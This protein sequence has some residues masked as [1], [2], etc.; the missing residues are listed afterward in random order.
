MPRVSK[1]LQETKIALQS[2]SG[3]FYYHNFLTENGKLREFIAIFDDVKD[4]RVPAMCTYRTKDIIATVFLALLDERNDWEDIED[5]CYDHKKFLSLFVDFSE[6]APSHDTL[7]RVFSLID[8]IDLQKAVV[9]FL[10]QC[11]ASVSD[12]VIKKD[13]SKVKV[14]A[15]DGKEEC[16][17]GRKYDT[18]E[19]V[20]NAQIMHFFDTD[21]QIC[22]ASAP[23]DDKTNEIPTAQ[24]MLRTLNIKGMVITADAM[25]AQKDTVKVIREGKANYVLGLKGNHKE[26]HNSVITEF[27]KVE[28]KG[29]IKNSKNYFKMETEKNHN[30]VEIRE[31]YRLSSAKFYQESDW[32]AL[33]SVVMYKKSTYNVITKAEHVERRYYLTDLTSTEL[34]AECI[35]THWSVENN[36]H[37]HLDKNF[38]EDANTTMN[39]KALHNLSVM[40]KM[41]LVLVK[42]LAPLFRNGSIKRTRKSFRSNYEENILK[43]FA[44]LEGKD[45]DEI[46][47]K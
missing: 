19:K 29:T 13:K 16:G 30:Q 32:D 41:I 18:N 24:A 31:F 40:N 15:L 33:K 23:I 9:S 43:L 37:W 11:V 45:L 25:N 27:E 12:I 5:F 6:R 21:T 7:C 46:F 2:V 26:L 22:I 14:G 20:R 4:S 8:T 34:I 47:N 1:T 35:R 17:S 42:L 3:L 38:L 10:Q 44:F 28:I 39:K 36:L